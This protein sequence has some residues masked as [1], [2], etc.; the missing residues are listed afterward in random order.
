MLNKLLMAGAVGAVAKFFK[1]VNEAVELDDRSRDMYIDA[2]TSI[3][4]AEYVVNRKKILAEKRLCNVGIK[5]KAL[6]DYAL[7]CYLAIYHEVREKEGCILQVE[8][9]VV[10][11]NYNINVGITR[12][13]TPVSEI[14]FSG[15]D[16][17]EKLVKGG[18]SKIILDDS[19]EYMAQAYEQ[20]RVANTV[21][22][23]MKQAVILL[24]TVIAYADR[25]SNL[26]VILGDMLRETSMQAKKILEMHGDNKFK[27]SERDKAIIIQCV[28]VARTCLQALKIYLINDEGVIDSE[29]MSLIN[30][31]E[32]FIKAS[33]DN[34][35]V[36]QITHAE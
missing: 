8:L 4:E 30:D 1:N 32:G 6:A 5:K 2:L 36:H 28:D 11:E 35:I 15:R 25:L 31:V 26:L 21:I 14:R 9:P 7:P 3:A 20:R 19:R 18:L 16:D 29:A 23:E 24:D 12:Y 22:A 27:Y 34:V 33:Y 13:S 10:P 17:W